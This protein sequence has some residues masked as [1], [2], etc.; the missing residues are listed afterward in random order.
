ML[1]VGKADWQ[2]QTCRGAVP[3]RQ[4]WISLLCLA[5]QLQQLL[6]WLH[7]GTETSSG[8]GCAA[9]AQAWQA[10]GVKR[11]PQMPRIR[12]ILILGRSRKFLATWMDI[13]SR[14]AGELHSN[15]RGVS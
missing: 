7:L 10:E 15:S 4:I 3:H 1:D 6:Y 2:Q 13:L 14:N 8:K 12:G 11:L 9:P 5:D